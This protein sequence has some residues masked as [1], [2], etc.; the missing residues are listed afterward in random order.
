MY[1][2]DLI[3]YHFTIHAAPY[4]V[5]SILMF[6]LGALILK[7]DIK[8]AGNIAFFIFTFGM[9]IHQM[10]T[11]LSY[12]S[13]NE[14]GVIFWIKIANI[15][16]I[17]SVPSLYAFVLNI[18]NFTNIKKKIYLV[19]LISLPFILSMF[20]SLFVAGIKRNNW[21]VLVMVGGSADYL[22]AFLMSCLYF[23]IIFLYVKRLKDPTFP[24]IKKRQI[25]I[26]SI[27]LL[28]AYIWASLDFLSDFGINYYPQSFIPLLLWIGATTFAIIRYDLFKITPQLASEAIINALTDFLFVVNVNKQIVFANPYFYKAFG[29]RSEEVHNKPIQD[30][31]K[32]NN[33]FFEQDITQ[34]DENIILD[35]KEGV[36]ENKDRKIQVLISASMIN[37]KGEFAGIAI[38][39]HNIE[40]IK[41][42]VAQIEEQKKDLNLHVNQLKRATIELKNSLAEVDEFRKLSVDRE[43]KMIELKNELKKFQIKHN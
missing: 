9:S 15:G 39:C 20:G 27:S 41:K 21:G 12:S 37:I 34:T 16:M 7:R 30:F 10:G 8:S 19:C 24:L 26:L 42:Y 28:L 6:C 2:F 11:S 4:F 40:D 33:N 14:L 25:K 43:L 31:L 5:S 23:Y 35:N 38:I 32:I 3:S 29:I 22:Y 17:I 36:L 18:L 1:I 13:I